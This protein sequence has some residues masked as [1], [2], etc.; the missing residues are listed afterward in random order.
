MRQAKSKHESLFLMIAVGDGR[1]TKRVVFVP[2]SGSESC[3]QTT[4]KFALNGQEQEIRI[5]L[6]EGV[7]L[8]Y[9]EVS[10]WDAP[11]RIRCVYSL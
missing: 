2:W 1:P 11:G 9:L 4:G 6:P 3:K 10:P 5:W 8:D 7:R